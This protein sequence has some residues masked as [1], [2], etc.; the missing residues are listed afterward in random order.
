MGRV[1]LVSM[2]GMGLCEAGTV[3]AVQYPLLDQSPVALRALS[4]AP[5]SATALGES[6]ES[7]CKV[8]ARFMRKSGA[9]NS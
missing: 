5:W 8:D 1:A 3:A 6:G 2:H 7:V 4:K 9:V